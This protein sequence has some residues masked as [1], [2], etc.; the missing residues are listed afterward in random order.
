MID[1]R[2]H[3]ISI[4][5]P[6]EQ[7]ILIQ[8]D[9]SNPLAVA[10]LDIIRDILARGEIREPQVEPAYHVHDDA[11]TDGFIQFGKHDT[12]DPQGCKFFSDI[13]EL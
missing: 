13:H 12:I 1:G 11:Q 8:D 7:S 2:G 3:A 5:G 4:C 6:L 10:D 9:L